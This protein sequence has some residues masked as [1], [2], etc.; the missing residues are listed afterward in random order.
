[1]SHASW[2]GVLQL[3]H[4]VYHPFGSDHE[5]EKNSNSTVLEHLPGARHCCYVTKNL[6]RLLRG[7]GCF[8]IGVYLGKQE[9]LGKFQISIFQR[10]WVSS[11]KSKLPRAHLQKASSQSVSQMTS[12]LKTEKHFKPELGCFTMVIKI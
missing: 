12:S 11:L 6:S 10:L 4:L 9:A 1:M 7:G 2:R 8:H 5:M 3:K